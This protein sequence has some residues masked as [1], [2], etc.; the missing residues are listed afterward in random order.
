MLYGGIVTGLPLD[1]EAM[2]EL[3]DGGSLQDILA[4]RGFEINMRDDMRQD[5]IYGGNGNDTMFIGGLDNA[6]GGTGA[7]SFNVMADHTGPMSTATIQDY[8]TGEDN[9]GIVVNDGDEDMEITVSSDG[10]DAVVMGDGTVLA[11]VIG[12]AGE[13]SAA[14]ISV[15]SESSGAGLLDP[16][17]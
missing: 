9:V 8:T 12:A 14:D 4:E 1:T 6:Y 11:R 5:E 3:S 7:D 15:M 16:N 2:Q 13:L 10:E 17:A